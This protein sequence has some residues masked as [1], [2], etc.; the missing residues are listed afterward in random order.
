MIYWLKYLMRG[1]R[2]MTSKLPIQMYNIL[3][4]VYNVYVIAGLY[5]VF[6]VTN[7][8]GINIPYND[9]IKHYVYMHYMSK[10]IDYFD[11]IFMILRKKNSQVSFLHVYHHATVIIPWGWIV[12]G[13]HANGTAA[14]GALINSIIH[15]M[16]YSHYFWTSMGYRNPFKRFLTQAQI[17]QFF[18][19]AGHSFAVILYEKNVP[20]RYAYGEM[21]YHMQMIYLFCKFYTSSY[22]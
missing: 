2:E 3:Q 12:A 15:M 7:V 14:F 11:T 6:P 10:Y 13:G 5:N 22:A 20:V 1:R 19:C 16:M 18:L 21:I 8:Y 4:I 9:S 17:A